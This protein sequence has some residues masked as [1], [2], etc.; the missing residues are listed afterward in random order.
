VPPKNKP[1]LRTHT[2]INLPGWLLV[3]EFVALGGLAMWGAKRYLGL[4]W[5]Y[6]AIAGAAVFAGLMV[7]L[8]RSGWF[9]VVYLAVVTIL[10]A[11]I[12][13]DFLKFHLDAEWAWGVGAAIA[14][15]SAWLHWRARSEIHDADEPGDS[16]PDKA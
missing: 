15:L 11:L 5:P 1:I 7:L 10:P 6:A 4:P 9:F 3:V 8:Y 12:A 14:V 13:A 16:P 2:E